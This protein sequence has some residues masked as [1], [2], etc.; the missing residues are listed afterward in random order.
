MATL[1][2]SK[3]EEYD[4]FGAL[5]YVSAV[6]LIYGMSI[7]LL[8]VL[9]IKRSRMD[10]GV[11]SYLAG[12]E[13]IRRLERQREQLRAQQVLEEQRCRKESLIA[14]QIAASDGADSESGGSADGAHAKRFLR[15][16]S[17]QKLNPVFSKESEILPLLGLPNLATLHEE[18]EERAPLTNKRNLV[19]L[20]SNSRC[21]DEEPC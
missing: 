8:I 20:R 19:G 3:Q 14:A 16:D 15:Q 18:D 1:V 5:C 7:V 10:S 11:K 6:V 2:E 12:I 9:Y 21:A 13:K 17:S 4:H